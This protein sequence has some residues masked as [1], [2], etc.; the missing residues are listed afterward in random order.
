MAKSSFTSTRAR[1][2]MRRILTETDAQIKPAMQDSVNIL[3]KEVMMNVP[4]DTGNL[5]DQ[6]TAHVAA[7]GLRGEVGLRTKRAKQQ[8]FYLRFLEF[9]TKGH[10]IA[11][12]SGKKVLSDG[13]NT[14]GTNASI[15]ALPARP[16]LQPAWDSKKSVII[17]RVSKVI[18]DAITKAQNL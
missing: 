13:D 17:N 10:K 3:H 2:K 5:E 11:V 16:V 7:N 18:T 8:G 1:I 9:G 4:R 15:P 6:I 12:G 14:F